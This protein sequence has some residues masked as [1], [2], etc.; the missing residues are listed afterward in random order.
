MTNWRW[1]QVD[2][3]LQLQ[4]QERYIST[5]QKENY[6]DRVIPTA[7][8]SFSLCPFAHSGQLHESP[9]FKSCSIEET[10]FMLQ[11]HT[12]PS[13]CRSSLYCSNCLFTS[14]FQYPTWSVA[15]RIK[16]KS[17][18]LENNV[19]YINL[20]VFFSF[21]ILKTSKPTYFWLWQV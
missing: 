9:S 19:N 4:L 7:T 10:F 17:I 11:D 12:L 16:L 6:W 1:S 13:V 8:E 21:F 3:E 18:H 5:T 20:H 15:C 14:G 2:V